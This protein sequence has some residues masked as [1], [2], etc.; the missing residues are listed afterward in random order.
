MLREHSSKFSCLQE[1]KFFL[2]KNFCDAI[3]VM[4]NA[5]LII[6]S[7]D[8]IVKFPLSSS[9]SDSQLEKAFSSAHSKTRL[10]LNGFR[11]QLSFA[12]PEKTVLL[13]PIPNFSEHTFFPELNALDH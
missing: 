13:C 11:L 8:V 9:T 4:V 5:Q 1:V 7:C 10:S 2:V 6:I 12:R 3:L